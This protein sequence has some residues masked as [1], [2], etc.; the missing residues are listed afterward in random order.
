MD[1]PGAEERHG[2][3]VARPRLPGVMPRQPFSE[4]QPLKCQVKGANAMLPHPTVPSPGLSRTVNQPPPLKPSEIVEVA[5]PTPATSPNR[6][7][8]ICQPN[9]PF[10]T[11]AELNSTTAEA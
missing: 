9:L 10:T 7:L 8:A 5:H 4:W 1:R 3:L 11:L 6:P 2:A